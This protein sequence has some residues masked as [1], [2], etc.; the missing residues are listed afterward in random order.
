VN[1][2]FI[3]N[4]NGI[5]KVNEA[6][7]IDVD[8]N[9]TAVEYF[10][11]EKMK[12]K[13]TIG[14]IEVTFSIEND[15]LELWGEAKGYEKQLIATIT[16]NDASEEEEGEEGDADAEATEAASSDY[17]NKIELNKESDLAKALLNEER[18]SLFVWIGAKGKVCGDEGKPVT[19]TFNGKPYFEA[20]YVRPLTFNDQAADNFIDGVNYGE[21]GSYILIEKVLDPIEW[22]DY[23]VN[24]ID[25]SI[26]MK[27]RKY[28]FVV[29]SYLWDYYGEFDVT[30]DPD[31]ITLEFADGT[32]MDKHPDMKI[33]QMTRDELLELIKDE[34]LKEAVPEAKYDFL[35]YFNNGQVTNQDF[36][37]RVNVTVKYGWGEVTLK[38]VKVLVKSTIGQD[39]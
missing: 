21:V 32:T 4:L 16:N 1:C 23:G 29:D 39:E 38:G 2:Q 17:V 36:Y 30:V 6:G 22:R 15:G 24:K 18:T 12:G 35:T 11:Y 14:D 34:K 10:F 31:D 9:V 25:T 27:D 19:I 7:V 13:K 26:P 28:P 3:N 33:Q 5:F 37:L 20:R 8:P